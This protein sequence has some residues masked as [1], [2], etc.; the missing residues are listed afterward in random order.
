ML[1][2]QLTVGSSAVFFREVMSICSLTL[3]HPFIIIAVGWRVLC[4]NHSVWEAARPFP[5]RP[6]SQTSFSKHFISWVFQGALVCSVWKA[7]CK[8]IPHGPQPSLAVVCSKSKWF[9]DWCLAQIPAVREEH[10]AWGLGT[11]QNRLS[12]GKDGRSGNEVTAPTHSSRPTDFWHYLICCFARCDSV[13]LLKHTFQ[14]VKS[15]ESSL[16]LCPDTCC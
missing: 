16:S 5:A 10:A 3:H 11:C 1:V 4:S 8:N 6:W 13:S 14:D 12:A 9:A 15:S 7:A 2:C